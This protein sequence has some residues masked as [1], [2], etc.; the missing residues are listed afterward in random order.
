MLK[1]DPGSVWA[2]FPLDKVGGEFRCGRLG[3]DWESILVPSKEHRFGS[4]KQNRV[5]AEI[6]DALILS[7]QYFN[8][9]P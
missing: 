9:V 7:R 8:S 3:V 2:S 5:N 6:L 1:R 4:V